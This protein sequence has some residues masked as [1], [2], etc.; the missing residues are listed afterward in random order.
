MTVPELIANVL[1]NLRQHFYT[2]DQT[3]TVHIHEF[4]R[5]ERQLI[6][7]IATYGHECNNRGWQFQADFI[8]RELMHLLLTIRT[9]GA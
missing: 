7:A 6:K 4:K 5:D 1:E 3:G 8:Y 9:N 2:D